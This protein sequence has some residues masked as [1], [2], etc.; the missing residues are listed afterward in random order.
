MFAVAASG[1]L[2]KA[3]ERLRV[4]Q[5]TLTRQMQALEQEV[6]GRLLE[7]SRTGVAL[8][9]AGLTFVDA[10]EP[11]L[12]RLDAA[13]AAA[14]QRA[15]GQS[16][17]LRIGYLIS[18]AADFLNPA[19][20]QLRRSHPQVKVKLVDLSPG[21]QLAAMRRGELDVAILG[22]ADASVAREF[23]VRR[24]AT[25]PVVV[26]M[27]ETH[28]RAR[29][30]QVRLRDLRTELFVGAKDTDLPG[31]NRWVFQLCRH[32][33]FRPRFVEEADGLA[34]SLS[35]L[36]A[37]NAVSLLPGWEKQVEVPGVTFRPLAEKRGR[38]DLQVAWQRGKSP[39]AVNALLAALAAQAPPSGKK[40]RSGR[41][42]PTESRS[43]AGR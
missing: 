14:R 26:A 13:L 25:L 30:A 31:Y 19:L 11:L 40:S 20:A 4:S 10:M 29:D 15:R 2:S 16:G 33:G 5:S 24:I 36:V 41:S 23:F 39:E 34:H 8:T 17:S 7:R 9:A 1:S 42:A 37:E 35:L 43:G 18:A 32:A 27:P 6:G 12:P 28:A 21:E 22:N 3:A 38:W